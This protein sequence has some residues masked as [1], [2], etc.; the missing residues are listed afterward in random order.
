MFLAGAASDETG[1]G[2]WAQTYMPPI[3]LT[4]MLC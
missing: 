3:G 4:D 1:N 2:H